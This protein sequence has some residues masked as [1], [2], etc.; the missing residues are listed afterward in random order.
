MEAE[1][2]AILADAVQREDGEKFDPESL[3][4]FILGLF[5]GTPPRL[6]DEL[7]KERRREV[8]WELSEIKTGKSRSRRRERAR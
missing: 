3:Q 2:R 4:D 8:Q 7:I 6:T 1:A 5:K